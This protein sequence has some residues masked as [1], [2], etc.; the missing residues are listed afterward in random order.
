MLQINANTIE[1]GSFE[2]PNV[3]NTEM[4]GTIWVCLKIGY[5]PNYSHLIGIMISKTIGFRGTL[6]SDIPI[7]TIT[8]HPLPQ[9][10]LN[11]AS[12]VVLDF[13][14]RTSNGAS[15]GSSG[16]LVSE[17]GRQMNLVFSVQFMAPQPRMRPSHQD[18]KMGEKNTQTIGICLRKWWV[19]MVS[20]GMLLV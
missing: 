9:V 2:L 7:S 14:P 3:V 16:S 19:T 15:S 13:E 10:R 8:M 4:A 12:A 18:D 11:R 20:G 5:I 6:F 1:N 17:M